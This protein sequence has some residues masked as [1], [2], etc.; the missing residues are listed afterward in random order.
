[1]GEGM[2]SVGGVSCWDMA[3]DLG[4]VG[5]GKWTGLDGLRQLGMS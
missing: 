1:M 4:F 3:K 5:L 2:G